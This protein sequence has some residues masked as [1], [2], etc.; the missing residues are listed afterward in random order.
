MESGDGG[1]EKRVGDPAARCAVWGVLIAA[2]AVF[3]AASLM[4]PSFVVLCWPWVDSWPLSVNSP[5]LGG[6][7]DGAVGHTCGGGGGVGAE[8]GRRTVCRGCLGDGYRRRG[9][10]PVFRQPEEP[11]APDACRKK[12]TKKYRSLTNDL[13]Y[14][15]SEAQRRL[16]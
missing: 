3:Q 13:A 15:E 4:V 1:G 6:F 11:S 12:N 7:W 10:W 2:H 8:C 14:S 9:R 5:V 16:S